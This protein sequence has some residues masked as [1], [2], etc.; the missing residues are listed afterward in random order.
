MPPEIFDRMVE[1][2]SP[3]DRPG[4]WAA[5]QDAFGDGLRL[6]ATRVRAQGLAEKLRTRSRRTPVA[7]SPFY[8]LTD[9]TEGVLAAWGTEAS[10]TSTSANVVASSRLCSCSPS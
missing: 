9:S 8:R 2:L 6:L 4:M 5:V 10:S 1:L 3:P 7:E